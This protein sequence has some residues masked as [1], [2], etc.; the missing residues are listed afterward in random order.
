VMKTPRSSNHF[1]SN[2]CPFLCHPERSRGICGSADLSW[3]CFST[4]ESW[5]CGPPKVMKTP[6]SSN[7]F[8]SNRCPFL[9]HPERSRGICGSADLSWKCFSTEESWA[10][11][12]PK[13]M[14]TPRSSNHFLSNRCPFL[15]HPER[16]RGICGSADLSWKCFSTERT[17]IS[18]HAAPDTAACAPFFKDGRMMSAKAISFY[19]KSGAA[20]WNYLRFSFN[21]NST[22]AEV[23]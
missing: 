11:G 13:V 22:S 14:K 4:E 19:N 18:C 2:R 10:C 6:R 3:K 9:C 21:K 16:S 20:E 15:C 8:L 5:A 7:H 12:P 17:R 23:Y 1:L